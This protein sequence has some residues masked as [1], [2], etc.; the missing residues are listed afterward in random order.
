MKRQVLFIALL[1]ISGAA[2]SQTKKDTTVKT[3]AA[4][5]APVPLPKQYYIQLSDAEI[6]DLFSLIRTSGKYTGSAIEDYLNGLLDRFKVI[7]VIS[8]SATKKK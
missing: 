5:P 1:L 4:P 6:A 3:Q 2:I 8:D 7:P